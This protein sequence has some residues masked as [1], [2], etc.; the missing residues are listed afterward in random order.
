V[1]QLGRLESQHEDD[2]QHV[3][4]REHGHD[5][6]KDEERAVESA[7]HRGKGDE[8]QETVLQ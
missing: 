4:D 8:V 3:R 5:D 7:V 1:Q 2:H 6:V